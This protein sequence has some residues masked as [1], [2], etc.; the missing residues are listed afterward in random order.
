M[1]IQNSKILILNSKFKIQNY[2]PWIAFLLSLIVYWLTV[3]PGA[4]YWDCPEYLISAIKL[5]IGHPPGNPGWALTHRFVSCFF[6][7][8]AV[9]V[10]VINMMSG[11]FTA[12]A[13]MILCSISISLM[14]WI[15]RGN[16]KNVWRTLAIS[17]SSLAGSLCF[18][19][20]DSPW[21]SA[22]EA[23]VYAMSL[24]LSALT[25]W[26]SLRWAFSLSRAV[27]VRW[28]VV[29]MYVIGFS[30]GVHQ[31]NL[32][33]LPAIA[34]VIA[35]RCLNKT[36]R[37]NLRLILAFIVGCLLVVALLKGLMPG[38]VALAEWADVIAVNSFGFPYWSGALAFWGVSLII[39]VAIAVLSGTRFRGFSTA[40]WCLAAVMVGYSVY[41]LI[42]IRAWANPP[43][44]EGN[45]SDIFRFSDYLDRRQ[46]GEAPLFYGRTPYS[47][48]MRIERVSVNEQGDTIRDYSWNAMKLRGRDMRPLVKN[49]HI[50]TRSGFLT[51]SDRRINEKVS[52]R[53]SAHGYV[54]AGFRAQP[55]YT[56]ELDMW[57]PRI[58]ASSSGDLAAYRD[59]AGMDSANM[60]RVR[61]SE[62]FDSLGSPVPMRDISGKPIEK[63][64]LRPSYFQSM[65]YMFGY[66]IGYMY[67]RY[68][69]WNYSGR[70]N[71][72]A[73]TG[74]IE[75]GNFIT[76]FPPLDDLMLGPQSQLPSEL[77][78]ENE[79]RNV[80][81]CLP[82]IL[83]L[84]GIIWLFKGSKK[85][86]PSV[87]MRQIA[88]VSLVLF[89][90]TG[91]AIVFY[92]NQGPGEPRERDYSFMGS[93]WTFALW[94]CFGMLL[95][96]RSMRRNWARVVALVA[97][98][99]LPIWML[100]ENYRDHDRSYRSATFDYASNLL[101]SLDEDAI[102]FVDGDNFIFPL[103][104]AQEVMGVR[105]DVAVICNAYLGSDWYVSQ[106]MMPRYGHDGVRMTATEG[107]IALGNYN[108]VRFP[109]VY[110]DTVRAVQALRDLYDDMSPTPSF[111]SRWLIMGKDTADSWVFDLLSIPGKGG[112]SIAGLREVAEVDIVATNALSRYP[113][114][115][116]WHQNLQ[117]N[118]YIGFFPY[119]RQ[120]LFT[121]KLMPQA[122]DSTIL[123]D[124]SLDVLPKMRWG[125]LDRSP[126]PGVD[127][128]SQASI[129]RASLIRL[130]ESLSKEGRH[131][132][133]LHVAKSA[134]VRFP[135]NVIP[136]TIR[137]H[138]DRAYFEARQIARVLT[139][140]GSTLG[141]TAAVSLARR[142]I[143]E[144]SLRT[145]SF[146][147][148]RQSLPSYRRSAL[149]PD[150]RNHTIQK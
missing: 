48:V 128:V 65:I 66:Q 123:V 144:D 36:K 5:E 8:P 83:G 50:P 56:P 27:R 126:Y 45:P 31:L 99:S 119:T 30:L 40:F 51:D 4:S 6:P 147:L 42:P 107:D 69:M 35:S 44:N 70:Q 84:I 145:Q 110:A 135:S 59:W 92:L 19:W 87:K 140:S 82:F 9:Q 93:F 13:V 38:S 105:R 106:L 124:E 114:P 95:I 116:Y 76:G 129:Q 139:V 74:E 81:W 32:L 11:V 29:L 62:A 97:V 67:L 112:G 143:V 34:M 18:A 125:E 60:V 57:I 78:V 2:I 24:F 149:S 89:L 131:D 37:S 64:A 133:A 98:C 90:L 150:S 142:I 120:A 1:T 39:V 113:R 7:G 103:W 138:N 58:Y 75:H 85:G 71:D 121:R 77:G 108:A 23:E 46:Y 15:W 130:A 100:A 109:G 136:F 104:F 43:V 80:Y 61:I 134:L 141:D 96:L 94:I 63:Y 132:Q 72:V 117:K 33:A 22:V 68:L 28:L 88:W 102:L 86:F 14:R 111:K 73:S 148:Y 12:L 118:R 115:I 55:I 127:V 137:H 53:D 41:I 52:S 3:D 20:S 47:R 25:V 91:V 10:R 17:A 79:G 21:Y 101:E 16:G 122:S 49:G 146:R 54:V 26:M